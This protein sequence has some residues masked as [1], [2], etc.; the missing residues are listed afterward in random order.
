LGKTFPITVQVFDVGGSTA[1]TSASSAL[2]GGPPVP[3]AGHLAAGSI[4][5]TSGNI[6][7]VN[8]PTFQGTASAFAI[9][10]L[11]AQEATAIPAQSIYLGQ[12]IAGP[13]GAW[14]LTTP[15]LSDGAY[16]ISASMI[17]QAGF[18][19]APILITSPNNPLII[20]TV[21]PRVSGLAFN[22]RTGIITV[23]IQDAGSGL[24]QQTL[25][26]SANYII[27]PKRRLIGQNPG[28][29]ALAPAISGYYS[30]ALSTTLQFQ[31]PLSAGRYLFEIKSGGIIDQAGNPLDGEFS[32]TLPSGNGRPGGNFIAQITVP[33]HAVVKPHLP[34]PSKFRRTHQR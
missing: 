2:V 3:L 29:A 10:Q 22:P 8:R 14:S 9:V 23:V 11:F 31:I 34:K 32:G 5:G 26:N 16:T 21:A 13:D 15:K 30:S 25:M 24:A 12:T 27:M 7:N 18:P 1:S 33:K 19:T 6:T 4:T 20:D 28:G 17:S